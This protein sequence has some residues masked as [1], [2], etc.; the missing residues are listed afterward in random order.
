MATGRPPDD[1]DEA[2]HDDEVDEPPAGVEPEA[3][4]LLDAAPLSTRRY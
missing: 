3:E 4:A 2:V 1:D